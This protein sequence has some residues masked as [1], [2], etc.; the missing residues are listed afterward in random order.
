LIQIGQQ[1]D[2]QLN[3][4]GGGYGGRGG[5]ATTTTIIFTR[6]ILPQRLANIANAYA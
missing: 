5:M 4:N 6:G 3:N 2:R 1:I